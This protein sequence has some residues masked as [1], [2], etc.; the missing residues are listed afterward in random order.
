VEGKAAT[1][2]VSP[3]Y[4]Y[5]TEMPIFLMPPVSLFFC[6]FMVAGIRKQPN[7][8]FVWILVPF[9]ICHSLVAHKETRFMFPM[10]FPMLYFAVYGW[11]QMQLKNPW[12]KWVRGAFYVI[13]VVNMIALLFRSFYPANDTL[14]FLR[15]MRS[16]AA[17]H[18][19]STIYWIKVGAYK[20][21][22]LTPHFYQNPWMKIV[23]L[24]DFEEL[25]DR[26]TYQPKSGDLLYFRTSKTDF[27]PAGFEKERVYRWY[28]DWVLRMNINN[29]V[30]RTRVWSVYRLK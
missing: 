10:I 2:G 6:W 20:K 11:D 8:V 3:W 4:W 13:V 19:E 16:Y 7:H 21:E 28:S 25:N 18:P 27:V 12:L 14:P 29:W 23:V 22:T 1:F 26:S 17:E 9:I 30:E 24:D 5:F 15:F